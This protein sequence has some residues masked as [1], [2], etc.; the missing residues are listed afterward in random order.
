MHNRPTLLSSLMR[1]ALLMPH[2]AYGMALAIVYPHLT[3]GR[4]RRLL[5]SWSKRLLSILH[6]GIQIEGTQPARS[7]GACLIVANHVSWLDSLVLNAIHPSRFITDL[8]VRNWPLIGWLCQRGGSIF[9]ERAMR[10][11]ANSVNRRIETLLQQGTCV[12]LFPEGPATDGRQVGHFHSA[13]IQPAIDAGIRLCPIALR[14]Q[15]MDGQRSDHAAFIGDMTLPRS[16]WRM[17]RSPRFNAL[18]VFTPA[19]TTAGA[20]RRVLARTAQEAIA[21]ELKRTTTQRYL[22]PDTPAEQSSPLLTEPSIL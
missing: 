15:D 16:V 22:Q 13:L 14:Y 9:V 2:L 3:T 1:G 11:H 5:K 6:I 17:L 18:L 4:R 20:N 10:P 7:D 19:L 8:E 21:Q 12:T